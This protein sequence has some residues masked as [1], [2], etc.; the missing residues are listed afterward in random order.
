MCPS[1]S[2]I[3]ETGF[4]AAKFLKGEN[5]GSLTPEV[6]AVKMRVYMAFRVYGQYENMFTSLEIPCL[7]EYLEEW[8]NMD[9]SAMT[10]QDRVNPFA[11]RFKACSNQPHIVWQRDIN[12]SIVM[13]DAMTDMPD[14]AMMVDEQHQTEDCYFLNTRVT[15]WKKNQASASNPVTMV[16]RGDSVRDFGGASSAG[17][18]PK[19]I[20]PGLSVDGADSGFIEVPNT[21]DRGDAVT[22]YLKSQSGGVGMKWAPGKI[23]KWS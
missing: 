4:S 1:N 3:C 23:K 21:A 8:I 18:K 5:Q 14:Y 20:D 6:L 7:D 9:E 22:R 17:F 16:N 19:E 2:T 13:G 10:P 12:D 15:K 11:K